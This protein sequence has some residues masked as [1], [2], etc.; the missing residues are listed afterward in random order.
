MHRVELTREGT[1]EFRRQSR[2]HEKWI[3]E[4]LADLRIDDVEALDRLLHDIKHRLGDDTSV[5]TGPGQ[6]EG[7]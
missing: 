4:I 5:N 3:H 2:A 1:A 6:A 7:R